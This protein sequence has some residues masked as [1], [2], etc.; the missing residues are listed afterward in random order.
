MPVLTLVLLHS[1]LSP[2]IDLLTDAFVAYLAATLFPDGSAALFADLNRFR[3][4]AAA[5]PALGP[6]SLPVVSLLFVRTIE[7]T[8]GQI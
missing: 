4:H 1:R 3:H 8:F 6:S 5:L 2:H 7:R